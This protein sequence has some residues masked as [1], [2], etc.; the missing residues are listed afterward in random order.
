VGFDATAPGYDGRMRWWYGTSEVGRR[1]LD[2][3]ERS[4]ALDGVVQ[5]LGASVRR[6]IRP[7]APADALHG[8]W[9]GHP[10]HPALTDIPIG[11]WAGAAALDLM[12]GQRRAATAMIGV[13][14]AA[15]V[16]SMATGASDWSETGREQQRVGLLHAA[17]NV[18]AVAL[19]S[20]SLVARVRGAD[21]T[22]RVLG[23]LGLAMVGLA[24]Y[25]GGHLAYGSAAG[26]NNAIPGLRRLPEQWQP[27]GALDTLP[28]RQPL[29][30]LIGGAVPVFVYR[31]GGEVRVL[32]EQCA[33]MAGPL[34]GGE[35]VTRDGDTCVVCPWHGSV[36]R[37]ADGRVEHG[38]ATEPQPVLEVRVVDGQVSVRRPVAAPS[39]VD[40][41]RVS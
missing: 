27:L 7:G 32:V 33:H 26:V 3:L 16:P 39:L 10:L 1:L 4:T 6:V 23:G 30:R 28:E 14:L 21:R 29:R 40:G 34:A 2:S 25:V 38:P 12:P 5:A 9:L 20:G 19:Y 24:G 22:G 37:L 15:A 11:A 35:I 17:A 36:F 13:G 18:A 41:V 8:V 31:D